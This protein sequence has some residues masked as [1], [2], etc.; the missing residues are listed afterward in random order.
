MYTLSKPDQTLTYF[1][2][3]H[4][5]NPENMQYPILKQCWHDFLETTG[6]KNCVVIIEG[7]LRSKHNNEHDAITQGGGGEGSLLQ[8]YAEQRNI[9]AIC[10]EPSAD[11]LHDQ[12]LQIFSEQEIAYL[13]FSHISMM[14]HRCLKINPALE[15]EYFYATYKRPLSLDAIKEMH[16][17]LFDTP[18][19]LLDTY[20][21]IT[22]AILL[23]KKIELMQSLAQTQECAMKRL[24]HASQI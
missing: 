12:L 8:F 14:Y 11:F 15:F 7:S 5:C 9:P 23:V 16:A 20:F 1:G 22:T 10:P 18:L 17:Q 3:N 13:D 21:F 19:D 24:L 6:G 4:S 2:A